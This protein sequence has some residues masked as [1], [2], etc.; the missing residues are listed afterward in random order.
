MSAG[1]DHR[2]LSCLDLLGALVGSADPCS[3]GMPSARFIPEVPDGALPPD[4]Q[5]E[6]ASLLTQYPQH[7]NSPWFQDSAT[8]LLI[9]PGV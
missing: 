2:E 4:V 6:M 9:R 5:I 1:K 3:E 7:L 8:G